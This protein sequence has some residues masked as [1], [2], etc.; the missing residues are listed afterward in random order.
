MYA[1]NGEVV[2]AAAQATLESL[3][4]LKGQLDRMPNF[5]LVEQIAD[6]LHSNWE[7]EKW[8]SSDFEN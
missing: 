7:A 2:R 5:P 8:R 6:F 4:N 3:H 1:G